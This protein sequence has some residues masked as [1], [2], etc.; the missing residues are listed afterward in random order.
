MA[1]I[2][3]AIDRLKEFRTA[4]ISAAVT[5]KIDLREEAA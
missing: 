1:R 2:Q 3:G 5:G 4:L